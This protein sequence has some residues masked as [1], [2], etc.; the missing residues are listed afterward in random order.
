MIASSIEEHA[1]FTTT[2]QAQ[3]RRGRTAEVTTVVVNC[4][5]SSMLLAII[6]ARVP[7]NRDP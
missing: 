7:H 2:R 3:Q 1:Q 4:A 5:C 6:S